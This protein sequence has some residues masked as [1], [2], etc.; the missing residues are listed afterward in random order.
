M[1][2]ITGLEEIVGEQL[3]D[4][5]GSLEF[6]CIEIIMGYKHNVLGHLS[7]NNRR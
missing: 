6:K 3:G 2:F 1:E 7:K 5:L 4:N